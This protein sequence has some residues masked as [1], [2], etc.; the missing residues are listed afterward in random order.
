MSIQAF[1]KR[2]MDFWSSLIVLCVLFLPFL[3]IAVLIK[4]DSPGPILF[5]YERAGKDGKLFKPFKFR[6]M[7]S[8]AI[9]KGLRYSVAESDERITKIG[10]FLRRYGIDE[11]P[12]LFN[13]LKGEMSLVGPRP[14]FRYQVERYNTFQKKR[15]LVKPGIIGWALIHG[16]NMIS[17]EERI[18]YDVWYAE[19]WSLWLDFYIILKSF[20]VILVQKQGVYGKGGTNDPFVDIDEK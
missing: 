3:I 6:T 15:L 20:Y 13:V 5:H 12:Q 16:R 10:S 1:F 18:K 14:T 19:H 2:Q 4:L 11:L 9:E 7:V 17:W 8:D